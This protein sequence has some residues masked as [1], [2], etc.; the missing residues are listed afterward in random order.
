MA[1]SP[2]FTVSP[3][4][5]AL[6]EEVA[7]LRAQVMAAAVQVVWIPQLQRDARVRNTHSSTAIEGNPL[8]QAQVR[9]LAE[10]REVVA[11]T[12]RARQE[13]LNYFAGLKFIETGSDKRRVTHRDVCRLHAV[14]ARGVMDQGREGEYR[15]MQV[16]VGSHRPPPP[17]QVKALMA[18]LLDWWNRESKQWSPVISSGIIHHRFEEIHPFADGNGRVGRLLALRELYRRGFDTHHIFAVDEYYWQD[19]SRYYAELRAVRD[20][21]G[22]LSGWLEYTA[23]GLLSA[24]R[25]AWKRIQSVAGGDRGRLMLSPKQEQLVR[26]LADEGPMAPRRIWEALGVSKQGALNLLNPLL[27]AGLVRREGTRK[28]GRYVLVSG[29]GE[30]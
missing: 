14:A 13:V 19:R 28:S 27:E 21:D 20:R 4:L 8:T 9:A 30:V 24:L 3:R 11:V 10:G 23:E 1:Y 22:D 29:S 16:W 2:R 17:G 26:M 18:E 5:L 25:N 15:K 6:V 12:D 7:T